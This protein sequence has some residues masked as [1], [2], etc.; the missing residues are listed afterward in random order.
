MEQDFRNSYGLNVQI[1]RH[2]GDKWIQ[3]MGK[4]E[5]TL[6]EQNEI[7]RNATEGHLDIAGD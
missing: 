1:F 4:D 5:L 7:G 3:T 2:H 6:E